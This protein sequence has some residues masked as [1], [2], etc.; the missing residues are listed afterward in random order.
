[1]EIRN[2]YDLAEQQNIAVFEFPLPQTGSLSVMEED[3]RCFI[4]M[5]PS[6]KDGG[7]R[8]RVHLSH[9]LGHCATGSFYNRYAAIDCRQRHENK[10]NK[11]AIRTL[12]PVEALDD[13]IAGGCTEVWELAERF[14][15]TEDFIR[16]A[17]CLYVHGNLAAELYF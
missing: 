14:G 16:K 5:D 9:E 12:I 7:V 1:M 4:G 8:E 10:A 15:V 6:V 3:G 17:V 2:L 13:A 11:W